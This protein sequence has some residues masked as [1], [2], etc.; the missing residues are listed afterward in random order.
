MGFLGFE[1]LDGYDLARVISGEL[2]ARD[3]ILCESHAVT[4]PR[5]TIRTKDYMFSIKSRPDKNR[6]NNMRWA[7]NAGYE[8]LE[9]ALYH[10]TLDPHEV[11]NLAFDPQYREIA[12][13]L[14]D[15]LLNIVL[16]DNRVEV[17]W[18]E[19]AG[20]TEIFRSNFAPGA[21]DKVLEL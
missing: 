6:G 2:K 15:K 14:K 8:E 21:D 13:V 4:G 5:A 10:L 12:Q 1:H 9:P 19:K 7:M 17:D 18:G 11:R 3:Y 16:G 20:G